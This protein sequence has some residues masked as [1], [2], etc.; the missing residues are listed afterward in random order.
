MPRGNA[1]QPK[2]VLA[3]QR[4]AF[5]DCRTMRL[6]SSFLGVLVLCVAVASYAGE[7]QASATGP[8]L[9]GDANC[10]GIVNPI[11][12]AF[13][14]QL[15]AGLIEELPCPKNGDTSRDGITNR[16]DSALIL[17]L[18]AGLI[19]SLPPIPTPI[20]LD[21]DVQFSWISNGTN[22]FCGAITDSVVLKTIPGSG[23]W[24]PMS[25][26]QGTQ[27]VIVFMDVSNFGLMEMTAGSQSLR[28]VDDLLRVYT[29]AGWNEWSTAMNT[30]RSF[31]GRTSLEETI[32]P[33]TTASML[34]VFRTP[35]NASGF[36]I[37]RCP[38]GGCGENSTLPVSTPTPSYRPSAQFV[39]PTH[40][41]DP[42][43]VWSPWCALRIGL[44]GASDMSGACKRA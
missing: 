17:Q 42:V 35:Q 20:I 18:S 23:A 28:L 40:P 39:T 13:I 5:Y 25:A 34:F 33:G 10:D 11:D 44:P 9:M 8:V 29:S 36:A 31:Y 19:D 15:S 41:A 7:H 43:A 4:V 12:S 27:F 22:I 32:Q 26:P 16:V 2:G 14:L 38:T 24:A 1:N 37:E 6:A 3:Q 30:A 21:C